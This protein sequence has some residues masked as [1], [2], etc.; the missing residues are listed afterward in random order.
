[1][2]KMNPFERRIVHL[3]VAEEEGVS[4]ESVG[5]GVIKQIVVFPSEP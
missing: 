2:A 4:T 3:A 5:D 1:M